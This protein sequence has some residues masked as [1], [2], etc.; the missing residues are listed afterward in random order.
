MALRYG[1]IGAGV[2]GVTAC[3][4]IREKDGRGEILVFTDE[5][6]P[7]YTRIRLPEVVSGRV[8]PERLVLKGESWFQQQNVRLHLGERVEEVRQDPLQ[9]VTSKGHYPVDRLLM[10]TGGY[11]F[12]PPIKGA[13]QKGVFSLRTLGDAIRIREEASRART[14]VVIGGGLL[15]LE[16]GN[17][18]RAR[19]L[20]VMVVEMF[21]RLLPRQMDPDGAATLR[22]A[23]EGMGFRFRLGVQS[24]EIRGEQGRAQAL[25]LGDGEE[26]A[27]EMFLISAGVRP[28]L[29]IA[30][31]LGLKIGK[32][33][34]VND[35]METSIPSIY[36]A[37]DAVEHNEVYYGIWPA[38]EEQGRVAGL[39]MAAGEGSYRGTVMSNQ[40]KVVGIDLVSAG[41]IDA[42]GEKE[43][44]IVSD[45]ARGVYRKI[46]YDGDRIAG[47]ILLGDITGQKN[48]LGAVEKKTSVGSHRG[49]VLANPQVI[50]A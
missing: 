31:G 1:I 29:D 37:G 40:L 22:K 19:G 11:S 32:G 18:F 49:R 46:V 36:A 13:D 2:A 25:V 48:I 44:E 5:A 41:D 33:I 45:P 14:A 3:Q 12:V 26:V 7:F 15:G 20:S 28:H 30:K 27:G 43:S 39:Q 42:E 38:A 23:M 8:A 6:Y 17:G 10:A 35:R 47:C 24:K 16:A 21:E 4:A 9:I 34:L 50:S